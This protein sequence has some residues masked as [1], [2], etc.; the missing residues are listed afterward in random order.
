[1]NGRK[2]VEGR[3]FRSGAVLGDQGLQDRH[4]DRRDHQGENDPHHPVDG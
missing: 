4:L 3:H 2:L 1:M